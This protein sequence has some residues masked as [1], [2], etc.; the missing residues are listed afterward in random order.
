[1][2]CLLVTAGLDGI[3]KLWSCFCYS[4]L[5]DFQGKAKLIREALPYQKCSFF[6]IVQTGGRGAIPMFKNYDVNYVKFKGPFGSIN[7]DIG[8]LF[9]A[10]NVP[11][12]G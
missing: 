1:M 8:R 3:Q 11:N 12:G 6:N 7:L 10:R 5:D 4:K 2:K 9:K